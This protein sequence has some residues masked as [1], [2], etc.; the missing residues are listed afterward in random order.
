MRPA[1]SKRRIWLTSIL[2]VGIAFWLVTILI[3]RDYAFFKAEFRDHFMLPSARA[4]RAIR[5]LENHRFTLWF[6]AHS[7]LLLGLIPPLMLFSKQRWLPLVIIT[8][9]FVPCFW[10]GTEILHLGAKMVDG[11]VLIRAIEEGVEPRS[12]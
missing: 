7:L 2:I 4:D 8:T 3:A 12:F 6:V 11:E 10:Y 1:A 5:I 9:L